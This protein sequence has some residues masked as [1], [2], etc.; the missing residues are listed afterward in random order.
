MA[1]RI[2]VR[3]AHLIVVREA[4]L[5]VVRVARLI[6]VRVARRIVEIA[7]H[8]TAV[9]TRGRKSSPTL[10]QA[11]GWRWQPQAD[12]GVGCSPIQATV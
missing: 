11:Q 9:K 10:R 4:H 2:V 12:G 5:I 7:A 3:V 1:R 8:Q 6:V